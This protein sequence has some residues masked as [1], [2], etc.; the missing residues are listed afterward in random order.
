MLRRTAELAGPALGAAARPTSAAADPA[1]S[2]GQ[3]AR[4][5]AWALELGSLL[6]LGAL[7][8]ALRFPNYQLIPAFTDEV[9]EIYRA[10]LT[11]RG[12]LLP[13]TNVD[14]Y[15]GSLW[16]YLLAAA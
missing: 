5:R 15:I 1:L 2:A 10:V 13:L 4:L 7:A 11:A 6:G 8:F 16:N 3:R 14:A 12:E 9:D